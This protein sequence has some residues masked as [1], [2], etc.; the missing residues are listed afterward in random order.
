MVR[1]VSYNGLLLGLDD[2]SP[3]L[4]DLSGCSVF[5]HLKSESQQRLVAPKA[6]QFNCLLLLL[7]YKKSRNNLQDPS[8]MRPPTDDSTKRGLDKECRVRAQKASRAKILRRMARYY[9]SNERQ[10]VN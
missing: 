9:G 8:N 2:L 6:T 1:S 10:S 3:A 4:A 7:V 5:L